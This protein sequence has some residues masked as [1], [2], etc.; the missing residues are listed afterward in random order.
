M[1][2]VSQAPALETRTLKVP[3][4][5]GGSCQSV[6]PKTTTPK[7]ASFFFLAFTLPTPGALAQATT[8]RLA[9]SGFSSLH[10][11]PAAQSLP[12][13]GSSAAGFS[14]HSATNQFTGR[15]RLAPAA[16]PCD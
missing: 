8:G 7:S 14:V 13:A 2:D 9:C 4:L 3:E 12:L 10:S 1:P 16:G 15:E 11:S 6:G 5:P